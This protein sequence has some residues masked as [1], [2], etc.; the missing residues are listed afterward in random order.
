MSLIGNSLD[1][2][3]ADT[4]MVDCLVEQADITTSGQTIARIKWVVVM[5]CIRGIK[6]R[7]WSDLI[8][9]ARRMSQAPPAFVRSGNIF[10]PQDKSVN[11]SCSL[12]GPGNGQINLPSRTV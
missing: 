7:G 9:P 12:I 4:G 6:K 11:R 3:T 1:D 8:E 2:A 10:G 5:R